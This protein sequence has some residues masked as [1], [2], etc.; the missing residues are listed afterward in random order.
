M[1]ILYIIGNGFDLWH[2]L[3]TDYSKFHEYAAHHLNE[4]EQ[5][6]NFER[7]L[8]SPWSDFENSLGKFNSHEF[9]DAHNFIDVSDESF[10]PSMAFGLEDDLTEQADDLVSSTQSQFREWIDSIDIGAAEPKFRFRF[11]GSFISF[12]YTDT[13]Q[14]IYEISDENIFHI[15]GNSRRYDELIFGHGELIEEEPE[16]DANGD[17]NRHMFSDAEAAAK[18]PLYAFKK[19]VS[20][21]LN[22]NINY[23]EA[24]HKIDVVVVIGHSLNRIDLPYIKKVAEVAQG[25]RWIVS[26]FTQMEGTSHLERLEA[27]GVTSSQVTLCE[28]DDVSVI[29][30]SM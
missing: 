6:M 22:R 9:Y 3:P 17:S 8:K 27:C 10:K 12:N 4:L 28:I 1:E 5:F 19:P 30:E 25:A 2:G 15:H 7:D 11:P 16:L 21:I 29:L 14:D 23:F 24:L 20:D 26:H 18:Y 13:L